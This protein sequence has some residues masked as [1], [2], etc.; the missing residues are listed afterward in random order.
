MLL[1]RRIIS[2]ALALVMVLGMLPQGVLAS[3]TE[4]TQG[5][6][7]IPAE[8]V[9]ETTADVTV[10]ETE[11]AAEET[12]TAA[13][14]ETEPEEVYAEASQVVV[15]DAELPGNEEL[16]TAYL[17]RLFYGNQIAFFGT[18]ARERLT[19][20]EQKFYDVLKAEILLIAAG[21]RTSTRIEIKKDVLAQWGM[22]VSFDI[23]GASTNQE[24]ATIVHNGVFA[25]LNQ[26]NIINALMYDC[27]YEMYWYD[28]TAG[29]LISSG[30]SISGTQGTVTRVM[31]NFRVA[32]DMQP[33][34]YEPNNPTIDTTFVTTAKASA[35]AAKAI[36]DDHAALTDYEKLHAYKEEIC[37]LTSY[38][39]AAAS[40]TSYT[41][42]ADPW[43]LIYVFD[44]DETTKV[45]CEGYSKAFQYLFDLST[46]RG[47]ISS[48]I[49]VG[50]LNGGGHMW[51]VVTIDGKNYMVDVTNSDSGTA[52]Q[53][54][55]LFLA[56]A[57]GSVAGGYTF[58]GH[59]FTYTDNTIALWGEENLRLEATDYSPNIA[60]GTCGENLT[61]VL[62]N[63]G[64]LVI[65]GSGGMEDYS[66]DLYVP[67]YSYRS[68]IKAVEIPEGITTIGSYAFYGCGVTEITVPGSVT[69][70]L[71]NA[72]GE[73]TDL[74]AVYFAGDAPAIAGG[75]FAGVNAQGYY[76]AENTTWNSENLQNYG[77]SLSWSATCYN[78]HTEVIQPR[79]AP[80][81][82][83][84]GISEGRY[85]S[86]CETV[87]VQ[88]TVLPALGHAEVVD[89]A[90]APTCVTPG[91]TEGRHCSRCAE[92]LT[93]QESI[94][95]LG[96]TEVVDAAQAPDCENT[97]LTEGKHC[98][99]CSEVLVR[100]EVIP[101]LGHSFENGFC[102]VCAG[103]EP[104]PLNNGVY[105]ISNAGQLYWFASRV[106][107]GEAGVNAAVVENITVNEN[108]EDRENLR[109]WTPIGSKDMPYTGSF[110]GRGHSITGLCK[111]DYA[112]SY[113][114]LFGYLKNA[115]VSDVI[116]PDGHFTGGGYVG[117]VAGYNDGGTVSGC[118]SGAHCGGDG[119][120]GGIVG[121]NDGG[122][123]E[124]CESSGNV[125]SSGIM[126]EFFGGIA[127]KNL[128]E[129]GEE[130]VIRG[131]VNSGTTSGY[132]NVGGIA[133]A[134]VGNA[135]I[136]D[137][138]NVGKVSTSGVHFA[139]GFHGGGIAGSNEAGAVI[140]G[141]SNEGKVDGECDNGGIAGS[142]AGR[143]EY[144]RN[145][146]EVRSIQ[147]YSEETQAGGIAGLNSGIIENSFSAGSVTALYRGMLA[148]LDKGGEILNCY[149]DGTGYG[150]GI[151]GVDDGVTG[152]M[153]ASQFASGE[154]AWLLN[155]GISDETSPWRQTIGTDAY[156]AFSGDIVYRN[157]VG[158]CLEENFLYE[159][160]NLPGEAV[161]SHS[162]Q[163][164]VTAP[165]CTAQGY[166]TY[167]CVCGESYVDDYTP[168]IPHA[169][170]ALEA[171]APTC[172]ETGLTEGLYCTRCQVILVHQET[173]PATGHD[174]VIG[175]CQNCGLENE[176]DHDL[177]SGKTMTLKITN[178]ATDKPYTSKELTW[179]LAEDYAP[180]A[181]VSKT[182]K[183]TAKKV[184]E[185]VRIEVIGTVTATEEKISV[186]V[187]LYPAVTQLEV[188]QADSVVNGKTVLMDFA[189]ETLVLTAGLFPTDLNQQV[190]WTVSDGKKLQYAD[191]EVDGNTL[192]ILNPRGKAGTVTVKATVTAGVKKTVTVKVTF[193][194]FAKTVEIAQPARTSIRSG[195]RL[196]L[197]AAVIEPRVVTKPGFTW[198]VSDKK[199][200]SISGGKLT[201]RSV[202]HPTLVTVTATSK[203]GQAS[204][205]IE[206]EILPKEEGKLVLSESGLLVTGTTQKQNLGDVL[207]LSAL[208]MENGDLV[209][210]NA[211]WKTSRASVATVSETG[212]VVC[213]GAGTARITATAYDGRT[214][215]VTVTVGVLAQSMTLSTKDG[216]SMTQEAG[217]TVVLLSSGKSVTLAAAI[218][219]DR[220]SRAVTWELA[221]GGAYAKVTSG[222]RL[223]ANKDITG[224]HYAVVRATAKDGSGVSGTIR[225]KLLPLATGV[226]IFESGTRVRSNTTYVVDMLATPALKL[227]ARVYPAKANQAV[228]LTSSNKKVADFNENGELVCFKPGTVTVTAKA[229]DG[230]NQKTTFK[231]TVVKRITG[232]HLKEGSNL[233]VT[234]GTSLRLAPMV[235]ISP[236]DATNK[237]LTWSVAPNDYGIT[238]SSTG[239]LKTRKVAS[240][241]TV[242]IMVLT[243]DGSGKMLS[244]DVTINPA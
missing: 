193:G 91:L 237:K 81:C 26:R 98:A 100:Q 147:A 70:I 130:A 225:V 227:S 179:A 45:V 69:A 102:T 8:S 189:D 119:S 12:V 203:D 125:S 59:K 75:A 230:S 176:P 155:G 132:G 215:T 76:A 11:T 87:F 126:N 106:N 35:A 221:E 209:P 212:R 244:F 84:A 7:T 235:E 143:I 142:N 90:V 214:A 160:A 169:E 190:T 205:T 163:A 114:G 10:A 50:A 124:N 129:N 85:C 95:A 88:Q 135:V 183:L 184:V 43:Q 208:T 115:S 154:V 74:T 6:E 17:E 2:F 24:K 243:Q 229:L 18:G 3:E 32:G 218:Q 47:D 16:Y 198:T 172:T 31:F 86:V 51:N 93:A 44:G 171:V 1:Y 53:N 48:R 137:C 232:L 210:E 216:K 89:A 46:F 224:V 127:G 52:G 121:V 240:P 182:G 233:S 25:Q 72:F 134:N 57:S 61:W 188:K 110:D 96:H 151:G 28:K 149:F 217:E 168:I 242:N 192:T 42:D 141:C 105:E 148:G 94:E 241:V 140:T 236:S 83:E 138:K 20:L 173:V 23:S 175:I 223:T 60:S 146:A 181:S 37:A 15:A 108:L 58:L 213:V 30:C 167:T 150:F 19:E 222:G 101:A 67:W 136:A 139:R 145:T 66:S 68:Q 118:I 116:L 13:P 199:A 14:A 22:T 194:S 128:G 161:I 21:E 157:Q 77:G 158:G 99:V 196:T 202:A 107:G 238:V 103:Y 36:V 112:G 191:Y 122:T 197:S 40:N 133:G 166:T 71:G 170:A 55:G 204:D 178:P 144:C 211:V 165:T 219:P 186:L 234:G 80:T 92:V 207:Q 177:F 41:T 226:Q 159:F 49:V 63:S 239:V 39:N 123:V 113:V 4:E 180:F 38:N 73:C 228:Q 164:E 97:G 111:D 162:Y 27:P 5:T 156:P 201:A 185:K 195:E 104:A 29:A 187:D 56:G 220:A 200:A 64:T 174:F 206:I 62:D 120:V 9:M 231:L 33:A 152:N 65:S 82:T 109:L 78:G 54:G 153:T 131:C 117:A 34:D 79:V